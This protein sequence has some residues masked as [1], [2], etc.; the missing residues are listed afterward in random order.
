MNIETYYNYCMSLP[1]AEESFPFNETTLAI[2]IG[3]KI[4]AMMDVE[5][6]EEGINLKCD[7]LK[8]LELRAEYEDIRPGYHTN[9]K[10]WNLVNPNGSL[11]DDFIR[12][13]TKDSYNLILNSLTKK[14]REKLGF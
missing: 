1:G 10:H 3:G 4:F 9:K 14:E 12:Q 11:E 13:L 7:P 6:F 2:K 8:A 5:A